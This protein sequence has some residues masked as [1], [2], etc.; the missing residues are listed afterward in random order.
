MAVV[1]DRKTGR[2]LRFAS[3]VENDGELIKTDSGD[4]YHSRNVTVEGGGAFADMLRFL[5]EVKNRS[6]E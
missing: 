6:N 2:I 5:A 3:K 4:I 1:R